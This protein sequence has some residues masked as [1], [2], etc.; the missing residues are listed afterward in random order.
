MMR[1]PEVAREVLLPAPPDEVWEALTDPA[2]LAA[3]FG[4][5]LEIE[6]RPGG[7]AS[8]RGDDGEVRIGHVREVEPG[9]RLAFEWWTPSEGAGGAS[10]VEFEL[11]EAEDGTR[12]TVVESRPTVVESNLGRLE[13]RMQQRVMA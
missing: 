3:W 6:P 5:D 8:Y 4:G 1:N 13:A 9:R 7:R 10:R 12:L 11:E 2:H